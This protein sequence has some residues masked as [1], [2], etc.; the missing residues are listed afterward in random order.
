MQLSLFKYNIY[1]MYK[2]IK[3]SLKEAIRTRKQGDSEDQVNIHMT[4]SFLYSSNK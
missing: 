2:T 4:G 3:T 1:H